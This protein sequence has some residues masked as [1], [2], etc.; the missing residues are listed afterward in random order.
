MN[1]RNPVQPRNDAA[2]GRPVARACEEDGSSQ[3][4]S[5]AV[6]HKGFSFVDVLQICAT[7]YNMTEYYN[8]LAYELKEHDAA[9]F[10]AA[11]RKAREWDYNIDA[12]ISLGVFYR[13]VLPTFEERFFADKA[14][15]SVDRGARSRH[16]S[17]KDLTVT[18]RSVL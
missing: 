13:K 2:S 16:C 14:E 15:G 5:W 9:D 17:Q 4:T 8:K 12:P 11:F 1:K 3:G 10:E 18:R 6:R 7:Y